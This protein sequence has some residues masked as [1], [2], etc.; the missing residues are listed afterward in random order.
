MDE[1]VPMQNPRGWHKFLSLWNSFITISKRIVCVF[2]RNALK[3]KRKW[4]TIV[5]EFFLYLILCVL[6]ASLLWWSSKELWK[7]VN[8]QSPYYIANVT[9]NGKLGSTDAA[10]LTNVIRLRVVE[11]L[12]DLNKL[13]RVV[14]NLEDWEVA[15]LRVLGLNQISDLKLNIG[16]LDLGSLLISL[17]NIVVGSRTLNFAV[18][19]SDQFVT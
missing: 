3:S 13:Q 12:E 15:K 8:G 7:T 17:Q 5:F 19:K 16:G 14:G 4:R 9:L 11:N 2:W 1:Q 10:T 6:G 18:T